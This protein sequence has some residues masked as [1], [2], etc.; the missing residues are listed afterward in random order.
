MTPLQEFCRD[1]EKRLAN[2]EWDDLRADYTYYHCL[3]KHWALANGFDRLVEKRFLVD[4]A[5]AGA[6]IEDH[7]TREP[8]WRWLNL[9]DGLEIDT[10]PGSQITAGQA[11][12]CSEALVTGSIF[13]VITRSRLLCRNIV[14]GQT[15]VQVARDR[16]P[17][18]T[19][20]AGGRPKGQQIDG[21]KLKELRGDRPITVVAR[22]SGIDPDTWARAEAEKPVSRR[23]SDKLRKFISTHEKNR[24]KKPK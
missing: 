19:G 2:D 16:D 13:K 1:W 5:I 14:H 20:K 7:G 9:L 3:G 4:A 21:K 18:R 22:L 15:V 17:K 23:T 10:G 11:D 24:P 12:G 8:V 6:M